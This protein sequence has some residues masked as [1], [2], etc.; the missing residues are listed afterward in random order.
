[1]EIMDI[2]ISNEEKALAQF[3]IETG[4]K[5]G[6]QQLRAMLNKSV[7]DKYSMLDG[8]L[9]SVTHNADSSVYLDIY[10]DGRYGSYS[11]NRLEKDCLEAFIKRCVHATG[12]LEED[13]DYSLPPV[14]LCEQ[15][16][17]EGNELESMDEEYFSMTD[18]KR[19]ELVRLT[20]L[21]N[22]AE[23]NSEWK[24]V[25]C[26]GDY[27]DSFGES[28]M[29]DS[30]GMEFC[31]LESY[32]SYCCD[33]TIE[34]TDGKRY[35]AHHWDGG[36]RISALNGISECPRKALKK[37]IAKINPSKGRGGKRKM[38]VDR[39]VAS[40][41]VS[42]LLSALYGDGIYQKNSF[43]ENKLG[44]KVFSDML[45]IED[46]ARDKNCIG[47]RMFDT[48]GVATKN[49]VLIDK[50]V[51]KEYFINTYYS[52]KLNMP[53]T[54]ESVSAPKVLTCCAAEGWKNDAD[55]GQDDIVKLIGNG[56]LVTGFNGGNC[57]RSS[58]DFS[59]GI[60]GFKIRNGKIEAPVTEMLITG[61]IIDLWNNLFAA[62]NDYQNNSRWLVPTLAFTDVSFS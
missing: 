45:V 2:R 59:Y 56:I 21:S 49:R 18:E 20:Q 60:E 7:C 9:D 54:I 3:C 4:L 37:A 42:P 40:R 62:G 10:V 22:P 17:K 46:R 15:N 8:E 57:N 28:Y 23:E 35:N 12:L 53:Q 14:E 19:L 13:R 50:G 11:T 33:L 52:R 16:A 61:N 36:S 58:G 39:T 30:N 5:E 24:V 41:L 27:S 55:F 43:L 25:S 51:V 38:V 26:E 44:E 47:A 34:T 48:E 1:M 6:A 31:K 29:I 32:F